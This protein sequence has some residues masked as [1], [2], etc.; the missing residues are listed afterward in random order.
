M[1]ALVT[2]LITDSRHPIQPWLRRWEEQNAGEAE[3]R[4]VGH[5]SQATGGD[6]LFLVSCHEIIKAPVRARYKHTL[7]LHASDLPQGKGMSPHV[8]QILEGRTELTVTLLEAADTLDAGDI[9]H[10]QRITVPTTALHDEIHGALF[11]AELDLMTWALRH[12]R[13]VQPRKQSGTA[14]FYR[15]RRPEDSRIALETPLGEAFN[16]LRIA[17]PERYPAFFEVDGV[18]FKI[19]IQRT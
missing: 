13:S 15:K 19:T 17:D 16:L 1:P 5:S 7:V 4:I 3:I 18:R 6:I 10:Q 8:W 11:Q 14:T 12:H 9:W 2:I